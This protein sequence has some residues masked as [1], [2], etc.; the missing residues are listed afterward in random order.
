MCDS[1]VVYCYTNLNYF[2]DGRTMGDTCNKLLE[3][4][5]VS[6]AATVGMCSCVHVYICI[7]KYTCTC[8]CICICVI[9]YL[10][11]LV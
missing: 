3:P 6:V 9:M 11:L 10:L 4:E 5:D 8:V 1:I 2:S 7:Y